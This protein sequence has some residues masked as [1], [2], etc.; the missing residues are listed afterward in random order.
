MVN[1]GLRKLRKSGEKIIARCCIRYHL[2]FK[3]QSVFQEI[4]KMLR[5]LFIYVFTFY[6]TISVPLGMILLCLELPLVLIT[7]ELDNNVS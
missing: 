3:R 4:H 7:Q 1:E 5:N 6:S 2:N